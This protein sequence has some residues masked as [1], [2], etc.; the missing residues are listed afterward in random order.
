MLADCYLVKE[1]VFLMFEFGLALGVVGCW[2][3]MSVVWVSRLSG[4]ARYSKL[5]NTGIAIQFN[6]AVIWAFSNTVCIQV[7]TSKCSSWH[8]YPDGSWNK[9]LYL[10]DRRQETEICS[11]V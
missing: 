9:Y 10:A 7:S 6:L 1:V 3:Y 11:D 4:L 8:K 2:L 5:Y